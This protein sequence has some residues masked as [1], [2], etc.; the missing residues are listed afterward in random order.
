MTLRVRLSSR[1]LG[2]VGV[3]TGLCVALNY[4]MLGFINVKLMDLFVFV[5]GYLMGPLIGVLVGSLTWLVYGTL[6]PYGFSLP[7][8]FVTI[9]G[10]SLYGLAGGLASRF[11]LVDLSNS[12][13]LSLSKIGFWVTNLKFG[14]LGFL[15][16]FAYDLLTNVFSGLVVGIPIVVAIMAG[17]LFALVHE[18]SNFLFF[19]F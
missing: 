14:L 5:S 3:M 18:V 15:L 11:G 16:T 9:F 12:Q 1:E 8:L 10:E 17:V 2:F 19:F 6:N 13:G 7:I 4:A